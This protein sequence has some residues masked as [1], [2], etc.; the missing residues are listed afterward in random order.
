VAQLL[1]S[2]QPSR[3]DIPSVLGTLRDSVVI[4]EI[5]ST[6]ALA[7]QVTFFPADQGV[8]SAAVTSILSPTAR[9]ATLRLPLVGSPAGPL[10]GVLVL[11]NPSAAAPIGFPVSVHLRR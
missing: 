2:R 10:R 4:L 8:A 3:R 9:H 6:R 1:A 7:G 5:E 11:G